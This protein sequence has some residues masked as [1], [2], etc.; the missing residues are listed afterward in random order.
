MLTMMLQTSVWLTLTPIF[1]R[2]VNQEK[3]M[4]PLLPS[5]EPL[6]HSYSWERKYS[7]L[8]SDLDLGLNS[9]SDPYCL[10]DQGTMVAPTFP[11]VTVRIKKGNIYKERGTVPGT[12]E[13]SR[14]WCDYHRP[15][16][17]H[18]TL[19]CF[20]SLPPNLIYILMNVYCL[21]GLLKD[22]FTYVISLNPHKNL[23]NRHYDS[24]LIVVCVCSFSNN[25]IY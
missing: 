9:G 15:F 21:P 4:H 7:L 11:D 18:Y 22:T 16:L 14:N 3:C 23:S 17:L 6:E 2:R 24:H 1:D 12:N 19:Q 5:S 8:R 10:Y 20:F 13:C 25:T